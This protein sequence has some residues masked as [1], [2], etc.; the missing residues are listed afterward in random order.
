MN[1]NQSCGT[2]TFLIKSYTDVVQTLYLLPLKLTKQ[3]QARQRTRKASHKQ[4][5][6]MNK[7]SSFV[8][9]LFPRNLLI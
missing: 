3:A 4:I 2:D 8:S 1:L 9:E 7:R 5:Q 6:R